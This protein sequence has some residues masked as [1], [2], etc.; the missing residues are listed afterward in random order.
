MY[1]RFDTICQRS[2]LKICIEKLCNLDLVGTQQ[3]GTLNIM[4]INVMSS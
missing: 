3:Y 1:L 2:T 4:Y